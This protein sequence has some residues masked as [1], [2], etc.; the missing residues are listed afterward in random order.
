MC[1]RQ[2]KLCSLLSNLEDRGRTGG[3]SMSSSLKKTPQVDESSMPRTKRFGRLVP[4]QVAALLQQRLVRR[5]VLRPSVRPEDEL[6]VSVPIDC[7]MNRCVLQ[8]VF[9]RNHS[10][11]RADCT[12]ALVPAITTRRRNVQPHV[13]I[14]KTACYRTERTT[15]GVRRPS[16]NGW[17]EYH[18]QSPL[19]L[20]TTTHQHDSSA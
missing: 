18:Y 10:L 6:R 2:H 7:A 5:I 9:L 19:S 8:K 15:D 12:G 14:N 4:E 16:R 11:W 3:G 13:S 1:A 17:A 20:V